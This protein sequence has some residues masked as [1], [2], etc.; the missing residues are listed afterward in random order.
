[1]FTVTASF[2]VKDPYYSYYKNH[3]LLTIQ[4]SKCRSQGHYSDFHCLH[5]SSDLKLWVLESLL[6]LL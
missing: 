4:V 1:M 5:A 6:T 2:K 3:N